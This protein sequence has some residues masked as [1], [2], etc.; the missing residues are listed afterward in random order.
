MN[1]AD[2]ARWYGEV[3]R[4]LRPGG[5]FA[6]YDVVAG[7]GGA[8]HCPVPWSRGLETSFLMTPVS[9]LEALL[10]REPINEGRPQR[11]AAVIYRA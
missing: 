7:L 1:I 6:M 5:H 2:R 9:I 11:T 4:V 8:L 10:G 3:H